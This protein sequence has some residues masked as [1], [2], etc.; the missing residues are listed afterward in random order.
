[1]EGEIVAIVGP[2]KCGKSTLLSLTAG[3]LT[4]CSGLIYINGK[5]IKSSGKNIGYM[6]QKDQL[7]DWQNTL[8]NI[9]PD[10]EPYRKLYDN[11]YVQINEGINTYGLITFINTY[12]SGHSECIRQRAALI[13]SLLLEPDILLL[14]EPFSSLDNESRLDVAD[15]IWSML[16]SEKKTVLLITNDISEA[17]S[18][19]DRVIILTPPP[20]SINKIIQI[21]LSAE[22]RTPSA[23]RNALEF[24]EYY[25]EIKNCLSSK[26]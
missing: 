14:D 20:G 4:P 9:S 15:E 3:L 17:I 24:S 25:N 6:L 7:L 21:D 16:R 23:A 10:Q 26:L 19:A 22:K 8:N 13:R 12:P 18:L 11:S 2:G 1:M 5:D